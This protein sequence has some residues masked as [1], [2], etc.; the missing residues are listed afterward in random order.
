MTR[1]YLNVSNRLAVFEDEDS[2]SRIAV[3]GSGISGLAAAIPSP[4]IDAGLTLFGLQPV[5]LG[6]I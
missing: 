2:M 5:E 4:G 1:I 6:G 3:I